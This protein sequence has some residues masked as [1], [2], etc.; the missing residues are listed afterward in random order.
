M[1]V[2]LAG[3]V[4]TSIELGGRSIALQRRILFSIKI[5]SENYYYIMELTA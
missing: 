2:C 5:L 3:V 1:K 4:G